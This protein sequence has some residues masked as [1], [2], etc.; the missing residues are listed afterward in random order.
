MQI[1]HKRKLI[2]IEL[3]NADRETDIIATK[4]MVAMVD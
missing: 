1:V 2:L 3:D 4:Q